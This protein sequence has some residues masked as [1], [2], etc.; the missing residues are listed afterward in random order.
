MEEKIPI[1]NL[2][3]DGICK[4]P[5]SVFFFPLLVGASSG[6]RHLRKARGC[7]TALRSCQLFSNIQ[8]YSR[9]LSAQIGSN[10]EQGRRHQRSAFNR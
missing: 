1:T 8:T 5:Q 7:A 9:A 2:G 3:G 4:L 6:Q 10:N